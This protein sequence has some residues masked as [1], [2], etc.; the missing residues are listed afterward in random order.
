M[1]ETYYQE[2]LKS[3]YMAIIQYLQNVPQQTPEFLGMNEGQTGLDEVKS[4]ENNEQ[5]ENYN[6]NSSIL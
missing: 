6:H 2:S 4:E 5:E 1:I 3:V